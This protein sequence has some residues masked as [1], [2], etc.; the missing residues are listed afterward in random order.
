[1]KLRAR[2]VYSVQ[3]ELIVSS[4]KEKTQFQPTFLNCLY[5]NNP[6]MKATTILFIQSAFVS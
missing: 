4:T 1:M 5:S 2:W 3:L 6:L